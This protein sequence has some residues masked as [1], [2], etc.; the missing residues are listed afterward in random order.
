MKTV[1]RAIVAKAESALVVRDSS[2]GG[3][4]VAAF[5]AV[6][7]VSVEGVAARFIGERPFTSTHR[8]TGDTGPTHTLLSAVNHER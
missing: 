2:D 7:W 8:R 4:A 6:K 5:G 1:T 3:R